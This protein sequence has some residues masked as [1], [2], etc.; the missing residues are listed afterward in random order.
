MSERKILRRPGVLGKVKVSRSTMYAM[1]AADEFPKPIKLGPR[2]VGWVEEEIDA[3]LEERI[4][5][6]DSRLHANN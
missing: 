5:E 3:W 1:I 2:S 6:R 4:K